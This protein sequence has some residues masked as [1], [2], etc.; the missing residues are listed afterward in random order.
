MWFNDTLAELERIERKIDAVLEHLD[1]ADPSTAA[2]TPELRDLVL[3]G[4]KIDAIKY[5]RQRSG[6]GL[7]KAKSVVD[8]IQRGDL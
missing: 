2:V 5:Y 8:A 4:R 1:I 3:E 6:E 7:R